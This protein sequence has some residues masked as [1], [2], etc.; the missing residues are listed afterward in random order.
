MIISN[1]LLN[2]LIKKKVKF[3]TGV[4]DSVLKNFLEQISKLGKKNHVETFNEGSAVSLAIGYNLATKKIPCVYLQNSGLGN[5]IN[6]LVSIAHPKVYSI[7][8]LL[9]I[10]WRGSPFMKSDEPQ[11]NVKGKITRDILKL[12][13]IK[14][15]IIR[16]KK[17]FSKISNL[18]DFAKRYSRPI[19]LLV[20]NN[21]L[22]SKLEIKKKKIFKVGVKREV[23]IQELLK[24]IKKDTSL[25]STTGYT[26]RELFQ[27]RK[28]KNLKNGKD[29]YMVGGM[30]HSLMV[31]LGLSMNKNNETI[32]LDGDGA[33]LMHLGSLRTSGIFGKKNLKHIVFNNFCHESVGAQRT[34][35]ENMSFSKLA[36]DLGYKNFF[37]IYYE[38][39]IKVILTKFLKS[40]G[41]SLLEIITKVGTLNDLR[42]PKDFMEIKERFIK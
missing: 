36:K 7:P 2:F 6:P 25:I 18:L 21:V 32:C 38:K 40:N 23:V 22:K 37:K 19:A 13:G 29:F 34:Y 12:L 17:D 9:L 27:I 10:G 14:F 16:T 1:E 30:G 33:L 39:D 28:N 24:K 41:P 31:S 4:P 3:F 35:T 15:L 26:S 8:L 42:R 20:E 11:H 5:A